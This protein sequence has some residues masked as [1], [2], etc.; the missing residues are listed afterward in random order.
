MVATIEEAEENAIAAFKTA[1]VT[2]EDLARA[3]ASIDG[4]AREFDEGKGLSVSED[5]TGHYAGYCYE[6]LAL[7]HRATSYATKR[8]N[9]QPV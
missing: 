2:V 4:K 5:R 3:W 6:A 7:L 8:Q 1:P 9:K